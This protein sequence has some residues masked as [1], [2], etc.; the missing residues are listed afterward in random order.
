M[1]TE[2]NF[3]FNTASNSQTI[4]LNNKNN[5]ERLA[6]LLSVPRLLHAARYEAVKS[7]PKHMDCYELESPGVVGTRASKDRPRTE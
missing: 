1:I 7:G 5:E 4:D 6:E 3:R 2:H